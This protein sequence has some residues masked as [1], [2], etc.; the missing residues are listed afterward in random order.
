M[1]RIFVY[2]YLSGGGEMAPG[3]LLAMG[4]SMRDAIMADLLRLGN[5][6]VSVATCQLASP[7]P[8]P[9]RPVTP[10]HGES[11]FDFVA[12]QADAHDLAWVVAPETDGLLARL[13]QCVDPGRWLGYEGPAIHIAT[14]TLGRSA[15]RRHTRSHARVRPASATRP[16]QAGKNA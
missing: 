5:H 12:R 13:K 10:R 1:N 2:E 11:A 3:E 9:A 8:E 16:T 4:Q 14:R 7:V 15:R 6:E